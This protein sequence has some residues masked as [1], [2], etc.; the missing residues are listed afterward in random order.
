MIMIQLNKNPKKI[1]RI[2]KLRGRKIE[3]NNNFRYKII[4]T[5]TTKA[6]SKL[7]YQI[8]IVMENYF[9]KRANTK[10]LTKYLDYFLIKALLLI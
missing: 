3:R 1:I 8:L 7:N 6:N 5:K 9:C 4:I 10:A 2:I